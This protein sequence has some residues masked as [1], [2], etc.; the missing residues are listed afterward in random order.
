MVREVS[1]ANNWDWTHIL[2]NKIAYFTEVLA[3]QNTKDGQKKNPQKQPKLYEP[4]FMIKAKE[5]AAINAGSETHTTDD[6]RA[7]LARSRVAVD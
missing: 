2:L 5:T 7:I 1:P 4:P 3:W 6:I